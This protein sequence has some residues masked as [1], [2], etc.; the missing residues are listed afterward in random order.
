MSVFLPRLMSL[1]RREAPRIDLSFRH[2]LP[3]TVIAELDA[4]AIDLALTPYD[5]SVPARF[6]TEKIFDEEFVIAAR[7][8]HPFLASPSLGRYC[9]ALHVL[10]SISGDQNGYV[11]MVLAEKGLSRRVALSVPNFM[12]ALAALPGS[13]LLAAVPSSLFA[14][15]GSRFGVGS[16]KAPLAL[17]RSPV[18]A[19]VPKVALMDP[20]I[21]WLKAALVRTAA[22]GLGERAGGPAPRTPARSRRTSSSAKARRRDPRGGRS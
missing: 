1:L 10:V 20:G 9:E 15:H 2:L 3:Q 19:V 6:V 5:D 18:G 8:G 4:G 11:D 7:L 22:E 13:D 12:L 17:A 16:V 21:A 14:V